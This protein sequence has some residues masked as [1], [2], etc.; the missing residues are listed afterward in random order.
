MVQDHFRRM[1]LVQEKQLA[2]MAEEKENP[3][4]AAEMSSEQNLNMIDG[5][6]NNEPPRVNQGYVI[7]GSEII[8]NAEIVI[9]ESPTAP[10]PFATWQRN[11]ENDEQDGAENFFWGHYFSDP[12]RAQDDFKQRVAEKREDYLE[13]HPSIR[14]QL[15]ENAAQCTKQSAAPKKNTP[16]L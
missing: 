14:A 11:I 9:A 7:T 16:E 3:L 10:S 13:P 8:G 2:R 5:V 1:E 4:K 6:P 12:E 15:K